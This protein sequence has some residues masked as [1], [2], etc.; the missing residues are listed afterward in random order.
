MNGRGEYSPLKHTVDVA[1]M[2]TTVIEFDANEV[3]D[4]YFHCHVLY[5]M[6]SGMARM[7]HYEG[8][9]LD[10]QLAQI[11]HKLYHDPWYVWARADALSN[12]TQGFLMLSNT[13]NI[14]TAEW[15]AGWQKVHR[16]ESG[17]NLAWD[18]YINRFFTLFAGT[19]LLGVKDNLEHARGVFG[20]RYLLPFSLESRVWVDPGRGGAFNLAKTLQ[21]TPRLALFGEGEYNTT[22]SGRY[23][24]G[25]TYVL[26]KN[27]SLIGQWHSDYGWGG[28]MQI[29]FN[30]ADP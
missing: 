15:E 17:D 16:P 12:M 4:W 28:G 8:Y 14:L 23:S 7:V 26:A 13:R 18:R 3:G 6:E 19:D 29:G 21:L 22:N 27:A 1:P 20:F 30:P 25:V 24:A 9:T 10:P 5:H 2:S 11:R